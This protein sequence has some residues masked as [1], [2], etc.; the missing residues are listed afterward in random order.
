MPSYLKIFK[1]NLN[2]NRIYGLDILR[3]FAILFVVFGHGE[4]L[5][6]KEIYKY[7]T[8]FLFDG[9][10]IFFVLSGFLI[11]AILIK[12]V[13]S[14]KMDFNFLFKFWKRRWLRT[15]PNYFLIFSILLILN[16]CFD[17]SNLS[18]SFS[19]Y[20]YF[21]QNIITPHP[22]FFSEAWSLSIEE[23]FYI[24]VPL[25][26][27]F[28]IKIIKLNPT[29]SILFVI[30]FFIIIS[31]LFRLFRFYNELIVDFHSWD[32][33]L[34]KQ[35][36]T[37]LDAIMYGV[38][39]AFI[40][41]K[42]KIFLKKWKTIFFSI[43][44]LIFLIQKFYLDYKSLSLYF[45]V[46]SFSLT[47]IATMFLFPTLMEMKSGKGVVYKVITYISL[48]SYSMYL[49]NLSIVQNWILKSIDFSGLAELNGYL[50]IAVKYFLY[51]FFTISI[52]IIL[53]KYFELPFMKL[54]TKTFPNRVV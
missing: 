8:F 35:V 11:G 41:L 51:W 27:F 29:Q 45:S 46:F 1:L 48:I 31:T 30:V 18:I 37:R 7:V 34:R 49:I 40:Y 36:F 21:S 2:P 22:D 32:T 25:A 44:V 20:F 33:I 19:K 13:N 39:G 42:N 6:E 15:L 52:S 3:A 50:F 9:V 4:Y 12:S 24:L 14:E 54:R 16:F 26:L 28:T 47:S 10:S 43:G 23:W 38:L 17:P 5:I 53:Y